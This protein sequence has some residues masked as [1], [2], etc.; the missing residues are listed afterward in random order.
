MLSAGRPSIGAAPASDS[1]ARGSRTVH[2]AAPPPHPPLHPYRARVPFAGACSRPPPKY[3]APG[4]EKQA[5]CE[6]FPADPIQNRCFAICWTADTECYSATTDYALVDG[7]GARI[8]VVGI[9]QH[10]G[11]CCVRACSL[12]H[13]SFASIPVSKPPGGFL[14]N[15]S[16]LEA[17]ANSSMWRARSSVVL[18]TTRTVLAGT[19]I[20]E[21]AL[22]AK[23]AGCHMEY[24]G[25]GN[26]KLGGMLHTSPAFRCHVGQSPS[27]PGHAA[28]KAAAASTPWYWPSLRK[29]V[30]AG[31]SIQFDGAP[32]AFLSACM[33]HMRYASTE[34]RATPGYNYAGALSERCSGLPGMGGRETLGGR[35]K[36]VCTTNPCTTNPSALPPGRR[37]LCTFASS[38][39]A[40]LD[41]PIIHAY[42]PLAR[43]PRPT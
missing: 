12:V 40:T 8:R 32:A 1:L 4:I 3:A 14:S 31:H 6:Y 15:T 37:M 16:L 35:G 36:R 30:T 19:S 39:P 41:L 20:H 43:R 34:C 24:G 9:R 11:V 42:I 23:G 22:F 28:R 21:D 2:L 29:P 38:R 13:T 25:G 26:V 7:Y 5:H 33:C 18:P 17:P 27:E 10:V